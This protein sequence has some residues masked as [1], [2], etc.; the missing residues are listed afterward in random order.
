MR[1]FRA[2]RASTPRWP[3]S[4]AR[5]VARE[6]VVLSTC[7]RAEIYAS[8]ETD[9]AAEPCGRF[10]S[11]YQRRRLGRARAAPLVLQ[12]RRG[13][14]DICSAS[15][16][17][18]TRWSS[19]SRRSSAR[20]RTPIAA[21]TEV[22]S[23][24]ALT[25][26]LFTSAFS[27]GKRV[28][29]RNRSR[30]RRRFRQ[31]RGDRAGARRSSATSRASTSSFS[32]PARWPS[33]PACTC[34]RS[35][36]K[37]LTIASRT[38]GTAERLAQHLDGR[39]VPWYV[40][41]RGADRGR[42]RRHRDRLD[43]AGAD[44]RAGRRGDASAAQPSAV[45]H[46]H[47]R[48]RAT[49]M[50]AVGSSTRCSCT[51]ST[52]CRRS[53]R[54]TWRGARRRSQRAERSSCGGSGRF[55]AWMQSRE[56]MPTVVALRQRFE[57][58][59]WRSSN[60]SNRK[61]APLPPE[62]RAR[63]DEITHLIVEKLLLTPTE[64]LK[65]ASDETLA[66][67]YSDAVNRLFALQPPKGTDESGRAVDDQP[68]S[69]SARAAVRS[70]SGRRARWRACSSSRARGRDRHR[71]RRTAIASRTRRSRKP[72]AR[73]C[74]SRRSKTPAGGQRSTSPSTAPRT[75]PWPCPTASASRRCC[76]ARIRATRWSAAADLSQL[77]RATR[78]IRHRVS[79]RRIAQLKRACPHARVHAA[80][81]QRGH[82][83]AQAGCGRIRCARPRRRR[84]EAAGLRRADFSAVAPDD[85]AFRRPARA[86]SPSRRA[87][88][89]AAM[90]V[91]CR[92]STT[93]AARDALRRPSAP[94][95]APS[96]AAA[97]CRSAHRAPRRPRARHAGDRRVA[98]RLRR[99]PASA[100]G[101]AARPAELGRQLA[102]DLEQGAAPGHP[103]IQYDRSAWPRA[104]AS[105]SSAPA[106]EIP[107]SSPSA[108]CVTCKPPTS[109]STITRSQ[110]ACCGW[111]ART[112]KRSTSA[113]RRR[114]R[115]T[116]TP[117]R[118]CSSR[119]RAKARR[120]SV[121]SGAIRSCST[122]AARKRC[123]CTSSRSLSRSCPAFPPPIGVPAY[124][125]IPVTYPGAGDIVIFVR[126]HEAET[127]DA[128]S[129]D[130]QRAG[131]PRRHARVLRGGAA[132]SERST[133][134]LLAHG[135]SP[136]ETAALIYAGTTAAQ[137]TVVGTLGVDRGAR[138]AAGSRHARHR[139]R[140][141]SARAPALVRRRGRCSAAGSS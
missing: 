57:E 34:R 8:A 24:G 31:L 50:P 73:A 124:A 2:A 134:P 96:A 92:P 93:A 106:R 70:R 129:V 21:A 25:N 65:S 38:L 55:T 88:T 63:V 100:R 58:S 26:R 123:S 131:G 108:A 40:A 66:V 111:R 116:R 42:H 56:I 79:I 102:G 138:A 132:E 54:R 14:R 61:L 36:V 127:D 86:S 67:A 117:S 97:S 141:R 15:P 81:R 140:R 43:R 107:A 49:S 125:G 18:S 22:K 72:A 17:G 51:T 7:N 104:P 5:R 60:G 74:S 119:R 52:T 122:A 78:P 64:Q 84:T 47:R 68:R 10:I 9:A 44:A 71:S 13:R 89:T 23:T 46:R 98:R 77:S 136:E 35:D 130:W 27:V 99:G 113:P 39:A 32:A 101:S 135:R 76:R 11:E 28:R 1:R 87:P 110:P 75:C 133:S 137:E 94:S 48:C 16:P 95:S 103:D 69:G 128:P 59:A 41:R 118:C 83:A 114:A 109:S 126:G 3:R 105:T 82:A 90:P 20:S 112:R 115:S 33:S 91:W 30:R 45:H 139:P 29:T 120:S 37:Q 19:A 53:C 121:S 12:R 85:D 4:A 62:A 6:A 80:A